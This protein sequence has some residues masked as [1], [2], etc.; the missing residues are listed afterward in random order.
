MKDPILATYTVEELAYEYFDRTER[1]AHAKR[2]IQEEADRIEEEKYDEA[3]AW[4]EEEAKEE[5]ER[6]AKEAAQQNPAEDPE[7]IKWMEEQM[8]KHKEMYG[9]EFGESIGIDFEED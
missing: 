5:A 8:A 4:A 3:L 7:N 1:A 9:D 6:Q 2:Q